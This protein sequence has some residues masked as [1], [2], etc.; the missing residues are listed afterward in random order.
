MPYRRI[1]HWIAASCLLA[2]T[3]VQ[4]DTIKVLTA[5]AFKP[6]VLAMVPG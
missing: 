6:V 1:A 3:G 5:G 2:I 4:A